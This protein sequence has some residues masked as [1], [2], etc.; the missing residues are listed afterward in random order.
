MNGRKP[1]PRV[2]DRA[3]RDSSVTATPLAF[4]ANNRHAKKVRPAAS[5]PHL[6]LILL[7]LYGGPQ[8]TEPVMP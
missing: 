6:P 5:P 8:L 2:L 7:L 4:Q 3:A 1:Q